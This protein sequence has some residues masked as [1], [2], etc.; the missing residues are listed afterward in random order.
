MTYLL[1]N[2]YFRL[3]NN[4]LFYRTILLYGTMKAGFLRDEVVFQMSDLIEKP[5]PDLSRRN[6]SMGAKKQ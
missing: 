3:V 2:N 1:I 4:P 5:E 6:E